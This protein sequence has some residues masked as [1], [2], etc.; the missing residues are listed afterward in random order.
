M[1]YVWQSVRAL[2]ACILVTIFAVPASLLAQSRSRALC[3]PKVQLL[4]G[5]DREL[6]ARLRTRHN[7]A[8]L[9]GFA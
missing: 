5:I 4:Q 2:V 9:R 1:H 3:H 8:D 6:S 7:H